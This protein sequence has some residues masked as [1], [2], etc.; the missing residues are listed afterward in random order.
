MNYLKQIYS[1]YHKSN[2]R[3]KTMIL[4]EF[5]KNCDYNRK[6]AI[7]LLNQP[8]KEDYKPS[9]TKDFTYTKETI[10]ILETIWKA[11]D[12]PWSNNLKAL[13]PLWLP[14][15]RKH[16]SITPSIEKQLLSISPATI[17]RRLKPKKYLVKKK[18][19]G[20]TKPG[21]LLKHHI[22]IKTDH[23]NV[24]EPGFIEID[25]VSHSGSS[26]EG[27]FIYSLNATD[28]FTT[29]TMTVAL[30]GKSQI[31]TF[32]A[33]KQIISLFPF[34]I[35]GIDSDNGSEFINWH[36][37]KFCKENNIQFTRSRPYKK[38]D[39]AHIEQKNWT[40]VR[41]IFGYLRYDSSTALSLMNNVYSNELFF[42]KNF[43]QPSVK[44]LSKSRIGS[45]Y[46]RLYDHPKT[47]FQRLLN[48]KTFDKSKIYRLKQI[49]FSLNPFDLSKILDDKLA[50]IY[51]LAAKISR[52][53]VL[54]HAV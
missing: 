13:I 1:R 3:A 47:P 4:N 7:W 26:A 16:Y 2:Y 17:D 6:Y 35:K 43:F 33:L 21:Y 37:V 32:N 44:L 20:T 48:S 38:D 23:W 10:S 22:P 28:I 50:K 8:L 51:R 40:H 14:W 41:K 31:A 27:D 39:N 42:L 52:P 12:Y 15:A 30:M 29:W 9:R 11:A 5:C 24:N 49:S 34:K 18:I 25:L 54:K 19:Y 36:L 53:S 46:K 45:K